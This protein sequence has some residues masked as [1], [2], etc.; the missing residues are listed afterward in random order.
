MLSPIM[1]EKMPSNPVLIRKQG[2]KRTPGPEK[3]AEDD[4]HFKLDEDMVVL[5]PIMSP[6]NANLE[7]DADRTLHGDYIKEDVII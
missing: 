2:K 1:L 5:S 7:V 4:D 6:R 3:V